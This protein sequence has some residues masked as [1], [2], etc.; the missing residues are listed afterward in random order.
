MCVCACVC[1]CARVCVVVCVVSFCVCLCLCVFSVCLCVYVRVFVCACVCLC[2]CMSMY[3]CA[4][5]CMRV[6]VGGAR[7]ADAAF[8]AC[9]HTAPRSDH[10]TVL[11]RHFSHGF[12]YCSAVTSALVQ[13]RL[14]VPAAR[15]RS[16]PMDVATVVEGVEV[17]AVLRD[18][19]GERRCPHGSHAVPPHTDHSDRRESLPWCR[20]V[21]VP[22][23]NWC[24][25][26]AAAAACARG[27]RGGGA[28]RRRLLARRRF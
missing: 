19:R 20:H 28:C 15:I 5:V 18:A 23:E 1:L 9:L 8:D 3:M 6:C 21:L 26:A 10:Y 4:C 27:T 22:V 13:A 2:V 11:N 16:L 17:S 12:I 14:R 7:A 25:A 24:A